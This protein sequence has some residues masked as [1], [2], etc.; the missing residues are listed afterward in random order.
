VR[1]QNI[2]L[3][4][5]CSR[6]VM[7]AR[8]INAAWKDPDMSKTHDSTSPYRITTRRQ[9]IAS[10]AMAVGSLAAADTLRAK[11]PENSMKQ[12]PVLVH[13]IG[14]TFRVNIKFSKRTVF[15]PAGAVP[16]V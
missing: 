12:V 16:S 7:P 1:Q 13:M 4:I 10:A 3:N 11:A 2:I 5:F 6:D 9:I 14:D 15:A 8:Q